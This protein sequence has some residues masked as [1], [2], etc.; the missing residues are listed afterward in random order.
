MFRLGL[1][2]Y[3]ACFCFCF[4]VCLFLF[5]DMTS[6]KKQH[7]DSLKGQVFKNYKL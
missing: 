2:L 5:K 4:C 7:K 1:I 3:F 6:K